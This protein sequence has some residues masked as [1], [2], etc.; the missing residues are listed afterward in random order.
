MRSAARTAAAPGPE[1]RD[2]RRLRHPGGV[3]PPTLYQRVGGYDFFETLTR[4]FYA[5]VRDDPTLSALYPADG[6][7]F[8]AARVHLRDFLIQFFG[9]PGTY[10][11][12]RG[13]PRLRMRHDP[14]VIGQVERDAWVAHMLDAL[15]ASETGAM[16]RTQMVTYFESA[17]THMINAPGTGP[18]AGSPTVPAAGGAPGSG[19]QAAASTGEAGPG[20]AEP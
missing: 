20:G 16:E 1:S 6:A 7:G 15:S 4:R 11:E 8:E 9:G 5:G 19:E 2:R 13:H 3:A 18:A 10:S 17:A 12:R 14:F